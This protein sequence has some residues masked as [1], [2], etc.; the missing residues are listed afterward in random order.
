MTKADE[1]RIEPRSKRGFRVVDGST[2]SLISHIDNISCSGVLCHT[3][4]PLPEM[5]KMGIVLELPE[6][7]NQKVMAEGLVVRCMAEEPNHDEFKVAI[8]YTKVEEK[9]LDAIRAYVEHDLSKD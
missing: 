6:P 7:V 2:D 8:L 4:R 1:R 3:V 5:T 9:D